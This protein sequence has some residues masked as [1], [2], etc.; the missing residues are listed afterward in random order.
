ML[1]GLLA[2]LL[3]R[4]SGARAEPT[5]R[6]LA[7]GPS[8]LRPSTRPAQA[9]VGEEVVLTLEWL[10]N[11]RAQPLPADAR[12]SWLRVAPRMVHVALPRP[13]ASTPTY[14]NSVLFG[15]HHGDWLGYDTIEYE[16]V[17]LLSGADVV[18]EGPRVRA[19]GAHA[20]DARMDPLG[21]AGS[22]WVAA[23]VR[24]PDGRTL[25]TPD[26]RSVD[27]LGLLPSVMRVSFRESDDFLGWLSSYE[28]VPD[29]FGSSGGRGVTHQADRYV[30]ADC[31]DLMTGA[32]RAMGRTD[33]THA[34]VSAL[35][36]LADAVTDVLL[37]G[38]DAVVRDAQGAPVE[39]RWG[40]DVQRGDLLALDYGD[41][42]E[43]SLPRAWD[44]VGALVGD[45]E[46][47]ARGV[48]DASD[49]YRNMTGLGVRD[50]ALSRELPLRVRVWRWKAPRR[51]RSRLAAAR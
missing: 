37:I 38:E 43:Q 28:H 1:G 46:E 20:S 2:L 10:E 8:D 21:A 42:P 50:V 26:A 5:L 41:D 36:Q 44:H 39:L 29:V 12:V 9:R 33:L 22:M 23:E 48:F 45:A 15:P 31:M 14:S 18:V 40:V 27:R 19:R 35:P 32:V 11:G 25:R 49:A 51:P 34:S 7:Q 24:L 16:Q 13:H 4:P 6:V 3:A 17:A 47:G 30:G